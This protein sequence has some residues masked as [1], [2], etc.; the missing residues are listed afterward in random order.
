MR[1]TPLVNARIVILGAGFGCLELSARLSA[2][3]GADASV[4]L[5]DKNEGAGP[6]YIEFGQHK[7]G[8]VDADF[9]T[10]PSVTA[11]FYGP[12]LEGAEE[13]REFASTS[14]QRWFGH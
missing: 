12:S 10:G 11:P 8:R 4:I 7:V 5:I 2:A 9:L 13:K 1:Y 14:R 3:L 6:C